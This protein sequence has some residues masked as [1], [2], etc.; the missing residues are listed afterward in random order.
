MLPPTLRATLGASVAALF[1]VFAFV[2]AFATPAEFD[3]IIRHGRVLDGSGAPWFRADIGLRDGRI[4]A[5]EPL[6]GRTAREEIDASGLYVAPGFIDGHSH[7]GPALATARLAAAHPQLAQGI[8]TV[9]IN[10]DGGGPADLMAQRRGLLR[11]ELG[12]NVVQMIGHNA[13]RQAVLGM[14]NRA[15]SDEELAR[16]IELVRA[17]LRAGAYGLSSGPYYTPGSYAT[18]D[19][20]VALARPVAEVD[21]FHSSHIRDEGSFSVGLVAAVDELI[22]VSR[23]SGV[24]GVVTHIKALGPDVWGLSKTVVERINAARASGLEIWAD[25]YPYDAGSTSLTAALVPPE[26]QAGGSAALLRRLDDP[27]E[28]ARIRAGM[29]LNLAKRNGAE[30]MQIR[31]FEAEPK[32]EGRRLAEIAASEGVSPVEMAVRMIKRGG[33]A[34][35]MFMIDEADIAHFMRQPW[36]MTASDGS[37]EAPGDGVPHPRSYGTFPRKI[38]VYAVERGIVTL[39]QAV[40]SMTQLPANVF[41][42]RDRGRLQ[43]G[44]W[45][46]VVVFDLEQVRDRATYTQPQ[47]LAE[48]MVHVLVNGRFAIR[49][50]RLTDERAGR[51]L[52]RPGSNPSTP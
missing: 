34:V 27:I 10:P 37:L 15:P 6:A 1:S 23:Q 19:E 50:G 33:A 16:M 20:L 42:L 7:A 48:G 9:L 11:Q 3:V 26:A 32:F 30:N 41:R 28:S 24:T 14:E 25:Q 43:P 29:E 4:V 49:D 45:G 5:V 40:H 52:A 17:A 2:A 18:V 47:Q 8:T 35:V 13:V 38:R 31:R 51:V 12:V 21:G 39:E 36:T 46:D 44:A 22:E